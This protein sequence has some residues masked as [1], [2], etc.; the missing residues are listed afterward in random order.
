MGIQDGEEAR[1]QVW[2]GL[3]PFP[4]E[5]PNDAGSEVGL[6]HVPDGVFT[7]CLWLDAKLKAPDVGLMLVQFSSEIGPTP[8]LSA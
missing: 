2:K 6:E 3:R 5:V 1:F 4:A 7:V 8:F